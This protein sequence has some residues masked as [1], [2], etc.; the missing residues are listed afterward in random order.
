M[1]LKI[2][3]RSFSLFLFFFFE[4]RKQ[5][6]IHCTVVEKQRS[7]KWWSLLILKNRKA[8]RSGIGKAQGSWVGVS[9]RL[10]VPHQCWPQPRRHPD[11]PLISCQASP[12]AASLVNGTGT[13]PPAFKETWTDFLPMGSAQLCVWLHVAVFT[14][15]AGGGFSPGASGGPGSLW[16]LSSMQESGQSQ[17]DRLGEALVLPALWTAALL[18]TQML[19]LQGICLG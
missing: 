16:R 11:L 6:A 2:H 12:Q 15:S 8:G 14:P 13:R 5:T 18:G 17:Q 3:V 10:R 7:R 9:L 4:G 1:I 19:S